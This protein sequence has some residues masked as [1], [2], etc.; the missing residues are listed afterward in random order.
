MLDSLMALDLTQ[1]ANYDFSFRPFSIPNHSIVAIMRLCRSSQ[2]PILLCLSPLFSLALESLNP[3]RCIRLTQ[4][5]PSSQNAPQPSTRH[6]LARRQCQRP[7]LLININNDLLFMKICGFLLPACQ[8]PD[9]R[10][11]SSSGSAT[12]DCQTSSAPSTCRSCGKS[13]PAWQMVCRTQCI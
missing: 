10:R 8:P 4:K 7:K 3:S 12:Q 9:N 5:L 11:T 13:W 6:K 1:I 2:H